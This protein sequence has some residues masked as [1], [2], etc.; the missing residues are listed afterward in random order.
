MQPIVVN[1]IS[2]D[3]AETADRKKEPYFPKVHSA[4]DVGMTA[5]CQRYQQ[6]IRERL[7]AYWLKSRAIRLPEA[8]MRDQH[9]HLTAAE[10]DELVEALLQDAAA[11]PDGSEREN[12][13]KLAAGYRDLA[14]M[15]R[16][17]HRKVN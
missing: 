17:V 8:E 3:Y 13:L 5:C 7:G 6:T 4:G 9:E 10:C 16:T 2:G 1:K 14:N 12:L 11:L 15:K